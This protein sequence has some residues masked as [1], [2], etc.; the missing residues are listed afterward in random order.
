[1]ELK[2]NIDQ[3]L[4]DSIREIVEEKIKSEECIL[5]SSKIQSKIDMQIHNQVSERLSSEIRMYFDR[6]YNTTDGNIQ[7]AAKRDLEDILKATFKEKVQEEV[8]KF[9]KSIPEET[10]T[11]IVIE[12]FGVSLAQYMMSGIVSTMDSYRNMNDS[13]MFSIVENVMRNHGF[14]I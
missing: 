7:G 11:K 4:N 14:N 1:M 10:M 12:V 9:I 5:D 3:A 6:Y 2:L 8:N 13:R